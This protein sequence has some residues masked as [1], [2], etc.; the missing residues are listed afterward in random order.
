MRQKTD[1][2]LA[3]GF[4]KMNKGVSSL[5]LEPDQLSDTQNMM[6]GYE[7]EQ[8]RGLS[9]LTGTPVVSGLRFKSLVQF[10]D[11]QGYTDLI[12]AHT[13]DSSGGE[14]IY[15]GS[16]LPPNAITWTKKYD[17]TASCTPCQWA[18]VANA[19]LIA[20]SKEFLIWRGNQFYPTG[21]WKYT[22]ANTAYTIF[23][24]ELFDNDVTTSMPLNSLTVDDEVL[25]V[26]EMPLDKVTATI[27]NANGTIAKLVGFYWT[28]SWR[29]LMDENGTVSN[30][31][32]IDDDCSAFGSWS[33]ADIGDGVSTQ[34]SFNGRQVF[35]FDSGSGTGNSAARSQDVGTFTD[36][37]T[38]TWRVYVQDWGTIGNSDH[39]QLR[40]DDG[41]L[42]VSLALASDGAFVYDGSTWNEVGTDIVVED[43]WQ[44]WTMEVDWTAETCDLY[45]DGTL[46]TADIDCSNSAGVTNGEVLMKANGETTSNRIFYVDLVRVGSTTETGDNFTDGTESSSATMAQTGN[47]SDE[48]KT[49]VQGVPGFAYKFKVAVALDSSVSE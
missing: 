15:E 12:L 44:E 46:V 41:T 29:Q 36:G 37:T 21:V 19:L 32:D 14:D 4:G 31:S 16:A 9:E 39:V 2:E 47:M 49:D 22:S 48:E 28:G 34:T 13:Y 38:A 7:W 43:T 23:A 5:L 30:G 11:L 45:L 27:G 26:S 6:P 24:D 1:K 10:R 20:N 40:L 42:R 33:D 25:I 3:H 35:K 18:N 17:L 8:R